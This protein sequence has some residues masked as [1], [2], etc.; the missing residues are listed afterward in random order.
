MDSLLLHICC[1]PC[2]T[3][4]VRLLSEKQVNFTT[5]FFNPNIY[6]REEYDLRVKT[7]C[8][9]AKRYKLE[10]IQEPFE[11]GVWEEAIADHAGVYPMIEGSPE[12]DVNRRRRQERCRMCYRLRFERLASQ[13]QVRGYQAISTSLSISPFQFTECL[14]EEL[15]RAASKYSLKAVFHDYRPYYPESIQ[16]SRELDMYRQQ[17]CGCRFSKE[18]ARMERLARK[19]TKAS[20]GSALQGALNG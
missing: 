11:P 5:Y 20:Q 8:R 4:P 9:F 2:S 13:A 15:S 12:H 1:G 10:V 17:F 6:T 14:S 19:N 16:R 3:V 18:E 7:F